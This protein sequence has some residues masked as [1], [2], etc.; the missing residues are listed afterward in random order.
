[1]VTKK[2][3][4]K[5]DMLLKKHILLSSLSWFYFIGVFLFTVFPFHVVPQLFSDY[6]RIFKDKCAPG[7]E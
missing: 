3:R 1:M 4:I 2:I 7:L 6:L 5:R